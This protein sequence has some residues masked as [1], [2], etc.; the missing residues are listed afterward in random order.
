MHTYKQTNKSIDKQTDI[1][2]YHRQQWKGTG[3]IAIVGEVPENVDP[4][5][6]TYI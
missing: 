3:G 5:R 6:C 1:P 2:T 4:Y